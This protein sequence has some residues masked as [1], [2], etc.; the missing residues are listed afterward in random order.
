MKS[1]IAFDLDGTLALSKQPLEAE[2]GEALADLLTVAHVAVI[3]GGDWPQF[4]KQVASR[5][6]ARADL[7]RLWL[8]PTTGTKLYR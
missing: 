8:M 1:L 7:S 4:D 3:S 5:L 2:M 6:P